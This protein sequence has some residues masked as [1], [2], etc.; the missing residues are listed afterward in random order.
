[1]RYRTVICIL[2]L[3]APLISGCGLFSDGQETVLTE[4]AAS[5]AQSGSAAPV[6]YSGPSS[7]EERIFKSPVIA[8]VRLDSVSSSVESGTTYRG[9]KYS[10]LLEF[11][12]SVLEYLKG[13]PPTGPGGSDA[14][15]IV[16]VWAAAPFFD[17]RQEAEAALPKIV[18][19]RDT[20]WD[21]HE[22]IVFLQNSEASL[23][24]TQQADRYYL[25]W[26]GSWMR[27]GG[28]DD[29][30][31]I[32]SRHNKLWLPGEAAVGAQSQPIGDQQRFLLGV[33]PAMGTHPTI[34]LGEMK[35]RIAA[36]EAKLSAGD[37]SEE[38]RECVLETYLL[39]RRDRHHRETQ[40]D[41]VYTGTNISPPHVHQFNSGLASGTVVY[42]LPEEAD[43]APSVP[44][45]IWLDGGD[46][47]LFSAATPSRNY[48]VTATRPLLEGKYK[49]YFNHRG[50]FYSLCDGWTIRYEWTV[51]VTAPDGTLHELF[52]DPVNQSGAVVAD[53]TNG[54]LKPASFTDSNGASATI[55]S[56]SYES[57]TVK[58]GV[59]PDGALA[60]HIVDFIELDGTV[61]LSLD[62]AD[63]LV[64]APTG[65]GQAG[66][67]SWSVSSQPWE[68]G[69]MLM[70]RIRRAR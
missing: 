4:G 14:N 40:P 60:G 67:L 52:F 27:Y 66:T 5:V 43:I 23:T 15:D 37:G 62:V 12:F 48:R 49:F 46:A 54:V 38:Y 17:T 19:A 55:H 13:Q 59:T 16:A 33:P 65:S 24:S 39:E 7:L 57:G 63:A 32:A 56:I 25:S 61:S 45:Q 20:R 36:V 10:A 8:R 30:Y 31:S 68:D 11:N 22:A 9:M 18:A 26:G 29:G 58:V 53:D 70:V 44:F 47:S 28:H 51:T 3:L 69:D 50:P 64:D 21:D 34:T 1:M 35:A 42:E 6:G 41:R 2:L